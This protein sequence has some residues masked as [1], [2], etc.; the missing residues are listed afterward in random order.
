MNQNNDK[1]YSVKMV[2]EV[3]R[4][5]LAKSNREAREKVDTSDMKHEIKNYRL[6]EEIFVKEIKDY[7]P[8]EYDLIDSI[9]EQIVKNAYGRMYTLKEQYAKIKKINQKLIKEG[10][11]PYE[12]I[13]FGRMTDEFLNKLK[14]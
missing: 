9:G 3:E 5:V 1:L 10:K 14:S 11:M 2:V 7:T 8:D 13:V 4:H 6:D 12:P